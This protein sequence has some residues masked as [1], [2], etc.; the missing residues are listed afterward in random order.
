[1]ASH[2]MTSVDIDAALLAKARDALGS[3]PAGADTDVVE[4]ALRLLVGRHA[5]GTA[6]SLSDLTEDEAMDVAYAEL[7]AMRRER[8]RVA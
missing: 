6:Q 8:R 2:P 1:M 4:R 7:R 5:L 3:S